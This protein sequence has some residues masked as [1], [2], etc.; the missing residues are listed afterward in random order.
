MAVRA[1]LGAG[2][3]RITRQLLTE[4]GLLALLGAVVG[5]LF[6]KGAL[7]VV[8]ALVGESMPR[9]AEI[10][11]DPRVLLFSAVVAMLTGLFF[12]L[13]PAWHARRV[14]LQGTLKE[15]GRG[16]TTSRAGLRHGLVIAEVALTFVLLAGAGLLL[17]SFHR[18]LQVNPGFV[19]DQVLTFNI[20]LPGGK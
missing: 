14:D 7:R 15:A 11:L 18:L 19:G 3:W 6:A 5:L 8:V 16:A 10:S 2:Q 12:G 20:N 1:A 17:L 9:A 13:A 4:S